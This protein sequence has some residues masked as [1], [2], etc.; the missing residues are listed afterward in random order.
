MIEFHLMGFS[1]FNVDVFTFGLIEIYWKLMCFTDF[2]KTYAIHGTVILKVVQ[3]IADEWK[4][5]AS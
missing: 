5:L 3:M 2:D 4:M 1:Y